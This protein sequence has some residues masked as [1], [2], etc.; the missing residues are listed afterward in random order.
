MSNSAADNDDLQQSTA[1]SAAIEAAFFD[2]VVA[3]SG[4]FDPF[5]PRGWQ[6]LARR[7]EKFVR[8]EKRLFVLDIGC[9]TGQSRQIYAA[10]LE[11]YIG[12]DL[13]EK[14][15]AVARR[16]FPSDEWMCADACACRRSTG[17]WMSWRSAAC[18]TISRIFSVRW[19]RPT[20]YSPPAARCLPSTPIC[21]TRPWPYSAGRAVP[22]T[23]PKAS[24]LMNGRS[25]RASCE[26]RSRPP[27][28]PR[29]SSA[30]SNIPY[31][32]VAPRVMNALLGVY[33]SADWL[34]EQVGL[35]RWFGTFV[36]TCGRKPLDA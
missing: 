20:A 19:S 35:G 17:R 5:A 28:S 33:N 22:C 25:C 15:L 24:A 36:V 13:S 34:Y 18:C 1:N 9:G 4:D 31:R 2:D 21:C 16:R 11:K 32:R 12:V 3:G 10:H 23:S 6:T 7:F 26:P 29:F 30:Q 8:P 14:A 27:A